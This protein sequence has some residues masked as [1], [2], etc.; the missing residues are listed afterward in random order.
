[1]TPTTTRTCSSPPPSCTILDSVSARQ[2]RLVSRSRAPIWPA[3]YSGGT[4]WPSA[5]ST[6][7]EGRSHCT[8]LSAPLDGAAAV[9]GSAE[10][11]PAMMGCVDSTG[12][13]P[14]QVK[15]HPL[16]VGSG[17]WTGVVGQ[18]ENGR[19]MVRVATLRD[20]AILQERK[21]L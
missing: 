19:L 14:V 11:G 6:E 16:G 4:E 7:L 5:T 20:G 18:L 8:R 21:S 10:A 15:A 13:A 3:R 17:D 1:M 2:A 9:R 12:G